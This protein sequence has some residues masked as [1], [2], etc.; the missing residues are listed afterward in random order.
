ML[1]APVTLFFPGSFAQGDQGPPG[2]V[3]SAVGAS[4]DAVNWDMIEGRGGRDFIRVVASALFC[5]NFQPFKPSHGMS[6]S[7]PVASLLP[8]HLQTP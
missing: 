7:S 1:P 8:P 3:V 5:S 2:D 6:Q 4:S